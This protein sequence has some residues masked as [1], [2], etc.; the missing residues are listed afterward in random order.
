ML[1]L[2][3]PMHAY[4]VAR[5]KGPLVVA[6]RAQAGET[7]T[8]LDGVD[9]KLTPD[10]TVIADDAGPI[11]IAGVMGGTSTEVTVETVDVF[12]ECAYFTPA[13]IRRTR[14][15]L[16]LSTEA[17]YRFERGIDRWGGVE[18]MRRCIEIIGATAGGELAEAPVDLGPG[19]GN[20]PRIFLRPA[21]AAQVLGAG[22][23]TWYGKSTS[24]R[25]WPDSTATRNSQPICGRFAPELWSMRPS[26]RS[27]PKSAKGWRGRVCS[28]SR[29]F[30]LRPPTAA[31]ACGC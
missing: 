9:R 25:K 17:S 23:P 28:R 31:G 24:S 30:R 8:T 2:N 21:R 18:A 19:P 20:P 14:K 4:D 26:S 12:L 11:G 22:V 1:E 27:R 15:A 5:L 16:G 6:R 10:M 29:P 7:V 3:Q 13:G